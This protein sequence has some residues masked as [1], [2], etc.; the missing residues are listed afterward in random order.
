L[1]TDALTGLPNLREFESKL[2]GALINAKERQGYYALAYLDLDD[3]V[4]I[5]RTYGRNTGDDLLKQIAETD[6]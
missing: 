2:E 6:S 3:F 1:L 5:C 4:S